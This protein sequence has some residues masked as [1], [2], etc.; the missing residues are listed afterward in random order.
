LPYAVR[1]LSSPHYTT[2]WLQ[3]R[4]PSPWNTLQRAALASHAPSP[5]A[6]VFRHQIGQELPHLAGFAA[7]RRAHQRIDG[8]LE[9]ARRAPRPD[10]VAAHEYL[11]V[12]RARIGFP[13]GKQ[14][15]DQ[16]RTGFS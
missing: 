9:L 13:I 5:R 6:P 4:S 15:F 8:R 16:L 3:K 7:V 2:S 10:A 12:P 1:L 11:F 14:P